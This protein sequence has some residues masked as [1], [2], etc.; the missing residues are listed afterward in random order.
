MISAA[1]AGY[2][3]ADQITRAQADAGMDP[4]RIGERADDLAAEL[5]NDAMTDEGRAFAREYADT[6]DT[7]ARDLRELDRPLAPAA[8]TLPD[9]T[10]HPD[11]FLAGRGWQ[12]QSGLYV[13]REPEMEREAG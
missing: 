6:A 12:A 8:A 11:P 10:P 7:Y 1:Q 5:W 3:T 2:E 4:D 9:G 13:R